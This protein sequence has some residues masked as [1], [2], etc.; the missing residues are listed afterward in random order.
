MRGVNKRPSHATRGRRVAAAAA[1]ASAAEAAAADADSAECSVCLTEVDRK[2]RSFLCSHFTC[3]G[4]DAELYARGDDRCPMCRCPRRHSHAQRGVH[5]ET[6]RRRAEAERDA[7]AGVGVLFF[8]VDGDSDV[9][10]S[11]F[12][13]GGRTDVETAADT[14]RVAAG[15]SALLDPRAVHA[16]RALLR[17]DQGGITAFLQTVSALRSSMEARAERARS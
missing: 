5:L 2:C 6:R 15:L 7:G 11:A 4:C 10:R 16:V 8:P 9:A 17:A 12:R 13:E 1:A 14:A 3:T